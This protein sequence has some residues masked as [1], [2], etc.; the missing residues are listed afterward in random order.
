MLQAAILIDMHRNSPRLGECALPQETLK[1]PALHLER[2]DNSLLGRY[3]FDLPESLARGELRP[4]RDPND[5]EEQEI[6]V[7]LIPVFRSVA[8][9]HPISMLTILANGAHPT[10]AKIA[11]I[12]ANHGARFIPSSAIPK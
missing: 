6:L 2:P 10:R 8:T 5:P 3:S 9:Q 11:A 1:L 4:L 12:V 7:G